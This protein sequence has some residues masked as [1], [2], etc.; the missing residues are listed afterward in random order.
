MSLSYEEPL[1]RR[2]MIDAFAW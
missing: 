1:I 2:E